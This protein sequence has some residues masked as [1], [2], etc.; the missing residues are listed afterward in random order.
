MLIIRTISDIDIKLFQNNHN[1]Y[2][3]ISTKPPKG[4]VNFMS[5]SGPIQDTFSQS[6]DE[7]ASA[8]IFFGSFLSTLQDIICTWQSILINISLDH[9]Y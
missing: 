2:M 6:N 3:Q 8:M 1:R 5:V 4:L 7:S 9:I